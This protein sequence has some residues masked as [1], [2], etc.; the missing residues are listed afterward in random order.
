MGLQVLLFMKKAQN[1]AAMNCAFVLNMKKYHFQTI[2]KAQ[3]ILTNAHNDL[4]QPAQIL[5]KVSSRDPGR[6]LPDGCNAFRCLRNPD[7][8]RHPVWMSA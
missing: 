1:H 5:Q 6:T 2:C 3:P 7:T 8:F 4:L